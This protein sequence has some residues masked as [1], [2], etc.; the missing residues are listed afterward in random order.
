MAGYDNFVFKFG[1]IA[2]VPTAGLYPIWDGAA[3]YDGYVT[4]PGVVSVASDSAEDQ[5]GGGGATHVTVTG[6]DAA[7]KVQSEEIEIGSSGSKLFSGMPVFTAK[8]SQGEDL[9]LAGANHGIITIT[10]GGKTC[11]I[12]VAGA[13][14]TQMAIYR[15]PNFLA[16]GEEVKHAELRGLRMYPDARTF[17]LEMYSRPNVLTPWNNLGT[18]ESVLSDIDEEYSFPR[19]FAPGED[20]VATISGA[21]AGNCSA[22]FE[23]ALIT[24]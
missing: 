4:T 3:A 19:R 20:I 8:V 24:G 13:G 23:I 6:L 10:C 5:V 2:A 15:I 17:K 14:R 7:G 11:A 18:Y 9:T 21:N 16:S 12:I 22:F 1:R